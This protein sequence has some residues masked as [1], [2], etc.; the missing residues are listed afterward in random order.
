MI[1]LQGLNAYQNI[2]R[3]ISNHSCFLTFIYM[4]LIDCKITNFPY[5]CFKRLCLIVKVRTSFINFN[6]GVLLD[7]SFV[8]LLVVRT[9]WTT[10]QAKN[11]TPAGTARRQCSI[12]AL[13]FHRS[14]K[15]RSAY[16]HLRA[17]E[18]RNGVQRRTR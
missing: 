18:E 12:Y 6:V 7:H 14:H 10:F 2:C 5:T 16:R 4:I 3:C 11:N 1:E 15:A 17:N 13:V 9:Y 8:L